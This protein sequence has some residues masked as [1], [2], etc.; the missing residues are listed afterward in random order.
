M[1]LA[2]PDGGAVSSLITV[3]DAYCVGDVDVELT[4]DHTYV[5]DLCVELA[6][7]GKVKRHMSRGSH[8]PSKMEAKDQED[9]VST[10]GMRDPARVVADW[11]ELR[12]TTK[13][14]EAALRRSRASKPVLQ[15]L[16]DC[17]GDDPAKLEA[18]VTL[19]LTLTNPGNCERF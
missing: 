12:A 16:T 2:V 6:H 19:P 7:D 14:V 1:P 17:F 11:P 8:T 13:K 5:G 3:T 4:I 9:K 15:S 18:S 10:A